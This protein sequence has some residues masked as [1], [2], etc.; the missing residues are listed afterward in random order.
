[1]LDVNVQEKVP[2]SE[3]G[4]TPTFDLNTGFSLFQVS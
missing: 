3:A 4:V 1:M 2:K